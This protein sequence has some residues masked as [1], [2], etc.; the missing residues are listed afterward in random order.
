MYPDSKIVFY[1]TSAE[2]CDGRVII[3]ST[4]QE[5]IVFELEPGENISINVAE[6]DKLEKLVALYEE[7]GMAVPDAVTHRMTYLKEFTYQDRT[8]WIYCVNKAD[9]ELEYTVDTVPDMD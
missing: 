6:H 1:R 3:D 5:Y 4:R 8:L 9:K 2:T 7:L